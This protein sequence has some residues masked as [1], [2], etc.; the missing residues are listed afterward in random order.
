MKAGIHSG[1]KQRLAFLLVL[2]SCIPIAFAQR[3]AQHAKLSLISEH[4][5]LTPGA[6][7]WIGIRFDLEPGWHIY[8]TN[9]GDSG[10]PPKV[11]WQAPGRMEVG[12]LQFPEPQRIQ[13][14]SLIDYGYQGNVI[15]LSKLTVPSAGDLPGN[16]ADIAADVRYLICR[17]I[18]VPAK[19]HVALALPFVSRAADANNVK[20]SPNAGVIQDTKAHLP[21]PLPS[22]VKTS[23]K[24][25]KDNLFVTVTG[26]SHF[27]GAI[28]DF[29]PVEPSVVD[30]VS[31]P[32]IETIAGGQ[33][34][35]LKKSD[36]LAH[37]PE[38]F[39]ALLITK[40]KAYSSTIPVVSSSS[41]KAN[42]QKNS[43]F[44]EKLR[45]KA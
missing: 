38:E 28:T 16:K 13:D 7:E 9:P 3:V 23:A 35:T 2:F 11:T 29:I 37:A 10:E 44:E 42:S 18:C 30:N 32:K 12:D 21:Q 4:T 1:V 31:R 33:V 6:S 22:S 8:W 25:T 15:L 5:A 24:L 17:E 36:Q 27:L 19:D 14:H 20:P 43:Y 45:S 34:I 39:H 40:D 41:Q 26:K